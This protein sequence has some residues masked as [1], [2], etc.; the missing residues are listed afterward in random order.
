MQLFQLN[1]PQLTCN[2][3]LVYCNLPHYGGSVT[4]YESIGGCFDSPY[5]AEIVKMSQSQFSQE[6][7]VLPRRIASRQYTQAP[8]DRHRLAINTMYHSSIIKD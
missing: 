5:W 4:L 1:L 3:P 8:P 6:S 7:Q 2:L